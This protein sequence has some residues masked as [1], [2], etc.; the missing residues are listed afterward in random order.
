MIGHSVVSDPFFLPVTDNF[1]QQLI[2]RPPKL[3]FL[4]VSSP[5]L[6]AINFK[7]SPETDGR[8]FGDMVASRWQI[9]KDIGVGD[10]TFEIARLKSVAWRMQKRL[11]EESKARLKKCNEEGLELDTVEVTWE[12]Y[13]TLNEETRARLE[14]F[15]DEGLELDIYH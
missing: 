12:C 10:P 3:R 5:Q 11:D 4:P 8:I 15:K 6:Q 14:E 2:Y 7:G 9:D 1:L 13:S